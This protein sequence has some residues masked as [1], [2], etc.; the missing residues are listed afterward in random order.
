MVAVSVDASLQPIVVKT[1][2]QQIFI[3]VLVVNLQGKN[4]Y[5]VW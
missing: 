5:P 3:A 1:L 2:Q 4:V